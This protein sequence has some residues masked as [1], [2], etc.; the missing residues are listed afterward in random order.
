MYITLLWK[1]NQRMWLNEKVL[2]LM[3][4][5]Q[6]QILLIFD[7]RWLEGETFD[8]F[9]MSSDQWRSLL[10][11]VVLRVYGSNPCSFT[12]TRVSG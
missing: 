10:L 5:S 7:L 4:E 6:D 11:P 2:M 1:A 12:Q 8:V 9:L 3:N